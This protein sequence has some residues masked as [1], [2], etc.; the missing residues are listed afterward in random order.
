MNITLLFQ[1]QIDY[2]PFTGLDDYDTLFEARHGRGALDHMPRTRGEA[3]VTSSI[4]MNPTTLGAGV[5]ENLMVRTRP[6]PDHGLPS[7]NQKEH[8][9]ASTD[10]SMMGHRVVSP[11]RSG[12]LI[13]EGPAIFT[14]MTETMLSALDQQMVLSSEAQKPGGFWTDNVLTTGQ[15]I[16]SNKVGESWVRS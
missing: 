3:V 8:V 9:S 10:P 11:I 14:A 4:G 6:I 16:G 5:I 7:T 13:G 15:L 1:N 2:P 12:P